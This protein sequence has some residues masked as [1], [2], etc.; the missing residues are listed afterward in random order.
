VPSYE[1]RE[2]SVEGNGERHY[3]KVAIW[4]GRRKR[5][6]DANEEFLIHPGPPEDP[7]PE[8]IRLIERRVKQVIEDGHDSG[9]F[10]PEQMKEH[11]MRAPRRNTVEHHIATEMMGMQADVH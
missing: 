11:K 10:T 5:T 7:L 1:I 4:F 9:P 6:P 3:F 8:M 2:H